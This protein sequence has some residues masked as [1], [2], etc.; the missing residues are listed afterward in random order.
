[1]DRLIAVSTDAAPAAEIH[2]TAE[3]EGVMKMRRLEIMDIPANGEVTFAPG[4]NHLMFI[5][6]N[7]AL[8]PGD[9]LT[10]Q[11][12][13]ENAGPVSVTFGISMMAPDTMPGAPASG[14]MPHHDMNHESMNYD[15]MG[16]DSMGYDMDEHMH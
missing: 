8:N 9:T 14:D 16:H 7:R 4:G 12:S 1:M 3:D 15:S 10:A 6:L 2:T 11:L 5:G 13:F